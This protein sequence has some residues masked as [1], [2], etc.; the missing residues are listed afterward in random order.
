[1]DRF[2]LRENIRR[3]TEMLSGELDGDRRR[4]LENLLL[5]ERTKLAELIG[6]ELPEPDTDQSD[7][8]SAQGAERV[9]RQARLAERVQYC[10]LRAEELRT[11]AS[12]LA[13]SAAAAALLRLAH[14]YEV[15]AEK[16]KAALQQREAQTQRSA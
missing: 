12:G 16:A 10:H 15:M 5:E 4:Q 7:A 1:M 13:N 14:D 9:I 6:N 8:A 3:F 11:A 2:V